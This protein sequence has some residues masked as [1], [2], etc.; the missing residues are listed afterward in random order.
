MFYRFMTT[1]V[2]LVWAMQAGA[3]TFPRRAA[4]E[5]DPRSPQGKCTIEVRVDGAAEV[6]IRGDTA[7]LRNLAGQPPEW[8]RFVCSSP[9]P[10]VPVGFRFA[11]VDGR[12]RQQLIADPGNGGPAVV[13]IDDPDNGSEGYT[14]DI[15]WQGA[16]GGPPQRGF[17]GP[18]FG[19]GDRDRDRD[20]DRDNRPRM[21]A[22]DAIR[23]CED[24]IID[25]AM[26]RLHAPI[27]IRRSAIDDQPGRGDWVVGVFE[28]RRERDRDRFRFQCSVDF[29]QGRI[30]SA[31]FQPDRR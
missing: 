1:A 12:G 8:R 30:R 25:Q 18:G 21:Q 4:I 15:T 27:V 26:D 2:V 14:F 28:V 5:G 10:Q 6:E 11:G 24:A 29:Y 22:D 31:D 9:M 7:V 13:R 16:G 17:I 23:V 3:Q 19:G 20:R